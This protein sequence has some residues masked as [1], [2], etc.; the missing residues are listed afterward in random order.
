[1]IRYGQ[2]F[3]L[4]WST[5]ALAAQAPNPN[6]RFANVTIEAQQLRPG[7]HMLTGAGGNIGVSSGEDGLLLIDDQFAPLAKRIEAALAEIQP[8]PVRFVI[9]THHHGDHTGGNAHFGR[10]GTVFAHHNVLKH[11]KADPKVSPEQWPVVTFDDGIEVHFN[12]QRIRVI[13]LGAG[14]T[15]GDALVWFEEQGVLHMGDLFFKDRFPYVDQTHGGTVRGYTERVREALR[16]TDDQTLIIPGHGDLANKA[17]LS[18]FLTMLED[19][20]RWAESMKGQPKDAW[21]AAG[22]PEAYRDWSWSFISE[23]RWIDTLW[24]EMEE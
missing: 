7:I 22:M 1:M 24:R 11:L 17:D 20:L 21:H 2:L 6:D 5:T 19:S 18:R 12:G 13:H 8:G 15:D 14:H 3:L 23:T 4:L 16:W 10:D 9:N